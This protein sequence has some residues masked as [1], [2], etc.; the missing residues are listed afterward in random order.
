MK[1]RKPFT[2]TKKILQSLFF[3]TVFAIF[4]PAKIY[5]KE[6][7]SLSRF[8]LMGEYELRAEE[9][10]ENPVLYTTINHEN[11][12]KLLV[13]EIGKRET[14]ENKSGVWLKIRTTSPMWVESG[15]WIEKYTD[16]WIFLLDEMELFDYVE[17]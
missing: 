13:L 2:F 10:F 1:S 16:F 11:G 7:K 14:R 9:G 4:V 12:F 8:M 3:M 6:I 17:Q 5:P 15:E